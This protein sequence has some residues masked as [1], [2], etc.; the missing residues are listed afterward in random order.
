MTTTAPLFPLYTSS[1]PVKIS[2]GGC[3]TYSKAYQQRAFIRATVRNSLAKVG[4]QR[5]HIRELAKTCGVSPQTLYNNFGSREEIVASSIAELVKYQLIHA[6]KVSEITGK[7][8]ILVLCD[9]LVK[10]VTTDQDYV[11]SVYQAIKAVPVNSPIIVQMQREFINVFI[12]CLD[13]LKKHGY[14]KKWVE[15]EQL[16]V[17]LQNNFDNV[18]LN[19]WLGKFNTEELRQQLKLMIGLPLLGATCGPEAEKIEQNL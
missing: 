3:E 17:V 18:I 16:A 1:T 12:S 7:N 4:Y 8:F 10:V 5:I 11:N 14:L 13:S 15:P 19:N 2:P 9:Q 6:Q